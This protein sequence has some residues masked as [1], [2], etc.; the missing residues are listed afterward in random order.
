M[1]HVLDCLQKILSLIQ[2]LVE[3][4]PLNKGVKHRDDLFAKFLIVLLLRQGPQQRGKGQLDLVTEDEE[5]GVE[6]G[7]VTDLLQVVLHVLHVQDEDGVDV[8]G[9]VEALGFS[10]EDEKFLEDLLV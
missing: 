9:V 4:A 2:L 8:G 3:N 6:D 5:G 1:L 7:D 10:A